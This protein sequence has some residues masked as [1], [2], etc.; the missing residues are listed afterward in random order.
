MWQGCALGRARLTALARRMTL[1]ETRCTMINRSEFPE[2]AMSNHYLW[3]PTLLVLSAVTAC[4][5]TPPQT[6][7]P[8]ASAPSTASAP[9]A[10]VTGSRIAVPV[11]A[12]MGLPEANPAQQVVSQ[13]DLERTGQTDVGA[14]L[15]QL[16]PALD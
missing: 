16:V 11:D 14:A 6:G 15:R 2:V 3:M 12:R 7:R 8:V 13:D 5:S 1:A 10:Y 4:T 9:K